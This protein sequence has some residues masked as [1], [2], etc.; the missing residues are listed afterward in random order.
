MGGPYH[1]ELFFLLF[2]PA[3]MRVGTFRDKI[4]QQCRV[5]PI[6]S[7]PSLFPLV[8]AIAILRLKEYERRRIWAL[9]NKQNNNWHSLMAASLFLRNLIEHLVVPLMD[10]PSIDCFLTHSF[11]TLPSSTILSVPL[12]SPKKLQRIE[13]VC[14]CVCVS[15]LCPDPIFA[16][17]R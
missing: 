16:I 15:V 8:G 9:K 13:C 7:I 5:L 4:W 17:E 6:V 1:L 2:F 10:E 11:I 14:V 3:Y 12:S